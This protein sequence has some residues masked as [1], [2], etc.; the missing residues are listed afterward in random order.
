MLILLNLD[1]DVSNTSLI[2]GFFL[3]PFYSS[4]RI[5]KRDFVFLVFTIFFPCCVFIV[6][7]QLKIDCSQHSV[8]PAVMDCKQC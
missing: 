4:F 3:A 5:L 2:N 8:N 1:G 6:C 7:R